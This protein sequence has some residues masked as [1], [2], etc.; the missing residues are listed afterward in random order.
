MKKAPAKKKTAPHAKAKA[1]K[2]ATARTSS[3]KS[4]L[5]R[6][7]TVP[8]PVPSTTPAVTPPI[9]PSTGLTT[10]AAARASASN[11]GLRVTAY[12]GDGSVLLAFNLDGTPGQGFAGFAIQ[13]TAPDN[14]TFYLKNRL[15]FTDKITAGT[16]PAQRHAILADTNV[17]P[18]QKFRWIDFSSERGPGQYVYTV[19]TMYHGSG[20]ALEAR[21][22]ASVSLHLGMFQSGDLQVGFTRGLLSSQAYV[23]Q[24]KN[25]AIRPAKKS[26]TYDTKPF[27]KQYEWLGFHARQLMFEFLNETLADKNSTLDLFAYDLDEPDI[28]AALVKFGPRLRAVLDNAPLHT[29][30]GAMEP[31]AKA[32]L[33]KSAGAANVKIGHFQRFAHSKCFIR[34]VN[35]QASSVLTGSTNF[36][37]RGLYVQANNVL[38]FNDAET[39]AQ[40]STAFDQTFEDMAHF[41]SSEIAEG[42]IDLSHRP[43]LPDFAVAFSPHTSSSVSLDRVSQAIQNAKSS[44]LF[45]IMELT[46]GGPVLSEITSLTAKRP[47][48]FSYGVTQNLSGVSLYK[49]GAT[50]GVLTPFSFLSKNVPPPFSQEVNGGPGQVIH[51]KF[52]IVD[53]DSQ[54]PVV[55]TGSSNLAAGGEQQNG[56]NLLAI[57]DEAVASIYAV[58]AMGL[59]DHFHFR[60]VMQSATDVQPLQ[61]DSTDAWW[62][63]YYKKG[64]LKYRDRTLFCP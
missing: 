15:T 21:E 3:P 31:L 32:A 26:I 4:A 44:V 24:F 5:R 11:Q 61:L 60:S 46:G 23:D 54:A 28:I 64:T 25:A 42:W 7:K 20:G 33:I 38:V 22:S 57:T 30:P 40:Y 52:V 2:S 62:Q 16:T 49:P 35:G 8:A 6:G 14:T 37:V 1:A 34:K 47:D 41:A 9:E 51:D 48:I 58:Q 50:S 36:S 13:C 19:S 55:F 63:D 43:N 53:F 18:Y 17:A 59:V 29:K 27:E 39:A 45:A 10:I 12:R 56:D